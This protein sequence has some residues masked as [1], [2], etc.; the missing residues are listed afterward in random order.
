MASPRRASR[1]GDQPCHDSCSSRC[2]SD[3]SVA[4]ALCASKQ[5]RSSSTVRPQT[6]QRVRAGRAQNTDD[7]LNTKPHRG[8]PISG[9]SMIASPPVW[10]GSL[11]FPEVPRVCSAQ[12]VDAC[13]CRQ[14][15]CRSAA[16]RPSASRRRS[17]ESAWTWRTFFGRTRYEVMLPAHPVRAWSPRPM[18]SPGSGSGQPAWG[19][20]DREARNAT[21]PRRCA[22]SPRFARLADPHPGDGSR[23]GPESGSAPHPR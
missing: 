13:R 20:G 22:R 17:E 4:R 3:S 19:I 9:G 2:K 14:R 8:Q 16:L 7:V 12:P 23:Q 21:P 5:E 10:A 1:D 6:G 18:Q 15:F 11:A